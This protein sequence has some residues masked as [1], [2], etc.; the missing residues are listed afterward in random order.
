MVLTRLLVNSSDRDISVYANSSQFRLN[1]NETYRNVCHM[2]VRYWYIMDS[3]YVVNAYNRTFSVNDGVVTYTISLAQGNYSTTTLATEVQS[4]LNASGS[5]VTWTV[6]YNSTTGKFTISATGPVTYAWATYPLCG[7]L[8]GFA[9]TVTNTTIV[10]DSVPNIS[11]TRYYML[12]LK[13]LPSIVRSKRPYHILIPNNVPQGSLNTPVNGLALDTIQF[14]G[15][16]DFSYLDVEI[17]DENYNLV[18]LRGMDWMI[19][20]EFM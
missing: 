14:G 15:S 5:I 4:K 16:V 2:C 20:L 13:N 9:S 18:D 10:S 1:Y 7:K 3:S 12:F 17:R 11:T 8:L 19:E 6:T